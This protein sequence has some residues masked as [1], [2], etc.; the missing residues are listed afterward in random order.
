MTDK[1]F[2][3]KLTT[4]PLAAENAANDRLAEKALAAVEKDIMADTI[5]VE[6]LCPITGFPTGK[7]RTVPLN[8]ALSAVMTVQQNLQAESEQSAEY[9]DERS[10]VEPLIRLG[11]KIEEQQADPVPSASVPMDAAPIAAPSMPAPTATIL[12]GLE[13]LT[14]PPSQPMKA[15]KLQLSG[16]MKFTTAMSCHATAINDQLMHWL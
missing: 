13:F 4:R 16:P 14:T 12:P 1:S 11:Q 7:I 8:Q 2:L 9:M 6:V 5:A 10:D 15:V 3:Q